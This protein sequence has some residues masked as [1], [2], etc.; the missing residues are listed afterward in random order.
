LERNVLIDK[1]TD[2][3]LEY[4]II[5][6]TLNADDFKCILNTHLKDEAFIENLINTI[7]VS[8]R[9]RNNVDIEV[10]KEILIGLEEIRLE[11]EYKDYVA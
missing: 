10:L 3:C 11:L 5:D 6:D 8:V 2:F 1:I 7:I 9:T 4:S